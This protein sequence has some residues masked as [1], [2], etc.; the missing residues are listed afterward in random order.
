MRLLCE[1]ARD[2]RAGID[3][4]FEPGPIEGVVVGDFA[5]DREHRI[6]RDRGADA[7]E[8][9]GDLRHFVSHGGERDAV[10]LAGGDAV[11]VGDADEE[12]VVGGERSVVVIE[13]LRA[14]VGE[15]ER[16]FFLVFCTRG[17]GRR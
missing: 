1:R 16:C 13:F 9:H 6:G 4:V 10:R 12:H 5:D 15:L 2:G 3:L 8:P 17:C 11:G 7:G 14:V